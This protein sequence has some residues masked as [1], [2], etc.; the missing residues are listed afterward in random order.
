MNTEWHI[1]CWGD[2]GFS[3]NQSV[4]FSS[5]QRNRHQNSQNACCGNVSKISILCSFLRNIK[6][7][8]RRHL[9]SRDVNCQGTAWQKGWMKR[10]ERG[11]MWLSRQKQCEP[12]LRHPLGTWR[13]TFRALQVTFFLPPPLQKVP[14]VFTAEAVAGMMNPF[15]KAFLTAFKF[16]VLRLGWK[17][18]SYSLALSVASQMGHLS[19]K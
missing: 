17:L 11:S 8:L 18:S 9:G 15:P 1:A 4:G 5:S 13:R 2:Y 16:Y 6:S 3:F 14:W 19:K 10:A 7:S 12:H